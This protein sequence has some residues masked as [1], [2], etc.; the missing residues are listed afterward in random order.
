MVL[1]RRVHSFFFLFVMHS[2]PA[3]AVNIFSQLFCSN[4]EAGT[5][6]GLK[7]MSPA[8]ILSQLGDSPNVS[9][10][11]DGRSLQKR[12]T[13]YK[14]PRILMTPAVGNKY[15][16]QIFVGYSKNKKELEVIAKNPETGKNE[17]YLVSDFP[18]NPKIEP[19]GENCLSCHP[20]G[21]PIFSAGPWSE[22]NANP[23]VAARLCDALGSNSYEGIPFVT[24]CEQL[25]AELKQYPKSSSTPSTALG[26]SN[27][28]GFGAAVRLNSTKQN[29][30]RLCSKICSNSGDSDSSAECRL[31]I[32]KFA[33]LGGS[34]NPN[35]PSNPQS[36]PEILENFYKNEQSIG[37]PFLETNSNHQ[38]VEKFKQIQAQMQVGS[39]LLSRERF[40]AIIKS[41]K[42]SVIADREP[43][44]L[45]KE[46]EDPQFKNLNAGVNLFLDPSGND[47]VSY[48]DALADGFGDLYQNIR[49]RPGR[50]R[51][52]QLIALHDS[53][54]QQFVQEKFDHQNPE[55]D[56]VLSRQTSHIP[57]KLFPTYLALSSRTCVGMNSEQTLPF[58]NC[59][60]EQ[61][62]KL[63][64]QPE[65]KNL[66]KM[67]WNTAIRDGKIAVALS[68]M[69][70]K[71][72]PLQNLKAPPVPS[73]AH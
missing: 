52:P 43:Q 58:F 60:A 29:A 51:R 27:A 36:P 9:M 57:E 50:K 25:R 72:C 66:A 11:P 56:A 15:G 16:G 20:N 46:K 70:Q 2:L 1:A 22:T 65:L 42:S 44:L 40:N 19:Q 30:E 37:F 41:R 14:N 34:T 28:F 55:S 21:Q 64:D 45:P 3:N 38:L 32:L 6:D 47:N 62:L 54:K 31:N 71:E 13:D 53:L 61:L 18:D 4:K 35:L 5:C 26:F 17:F 73:K 10:I 33:V 69:A 24:D 7:G 63:M 48:D 68:E 59:S 8:N 67:D 49:T 23:R 12:H 39:P